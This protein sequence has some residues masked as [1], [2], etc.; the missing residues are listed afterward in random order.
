MSR[1]L[2]MC[3]VNPDF[4]EAMR[5]LVGTQSDIM[6]RAGI[7][8]NSWAKI[9]AGMPVRLSVGERLRDRVIGELGKSPAVRRMFAGGPDGEAIDLA[10][11]AAA[12]L[13]PV[14]VDPAGTRGPVPGPREPYLGAAT[15]TAI[16]GS[17]G[18]RVG[19]GIGH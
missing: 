2:N 15:R 14:T 4:V 19:A 10:A 11:L 12:F 13:T 8:W 16:P 17:G 9:V 18:A 3:L 1:T 7:S 6:V 5:D